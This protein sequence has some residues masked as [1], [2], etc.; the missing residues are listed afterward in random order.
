[1]NKWSARMTGLLFLLSTCAYLIGSGLLNPILKRP[2]LLT[3]SSLNQTIV[4]TG[5]FLE[6]INAIAVVGIAILLYPVLRKYNEALMLGYF[7]SRVIESAILMFSLISPILL[8]MLS[9]EL[10]GAEPSGRPYLQMIAKVAVESHFILFELAM[11]VLSLGS[12][13]FCYVLYR[14][15]LVPRFLSII[16]FMGYA[17]LLTSSCLAI[18]GLDVGAILY[19]PGAIFEILLPLWLMVKGFNLRAENPR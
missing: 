4:V 7:A 19:I 13:L 2:E 5:L 14:S 1:M 3:D 12:L 6:L 16:G 10:K 17:G 8:I 18:S 11:I 9:G 15:R